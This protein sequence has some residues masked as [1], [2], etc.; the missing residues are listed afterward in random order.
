[1][2][3]L[4]SENQNLKSFL[5]AMV[6]NY[7]LPQ[8]LVFE[9]QTLS[10]LPD[11]LHSDRGSAGLDLEQS[12]NDMNFMNEDESNLFLD[13]PLPSDRDDFL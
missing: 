12:K 4:R 2:K 7:T 3:L 1:M 13:K 8:E 6:D 11:I 9:V 10:E 5:K